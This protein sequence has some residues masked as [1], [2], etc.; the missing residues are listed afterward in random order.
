ML[1]KGLLIMHVTEVFQHTLGECA[2]EY[3]ASRRSSLPASARSETASAAVEPTAC[4]ALDAAPSASKRRRTPHCRHPP[5]PT[6][7]FSR[8]MH[9]TGPGRIVQKPA[10]TKPPIW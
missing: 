8:S 10:P 6:R 2:G 1:D 5:D 7:H 4:R 3:S 9:V